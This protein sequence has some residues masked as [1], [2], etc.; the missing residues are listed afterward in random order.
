MYPAKMP[1]TSHCLQKFGDFIFCSSKIMM[2]YL[3]K[4]ELVDPPSNS[5]AISVN[6][7]VKIRVNAVVLDSILVLFLNAVVFVVKTRHP[8]R[9]TAP[10]P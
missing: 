2:F 9:S 10:Q 5:L 4:S 3:L 7:E 6:Y 8:K 1:L